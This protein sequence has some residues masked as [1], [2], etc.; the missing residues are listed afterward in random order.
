MAKASTSRNILEKAGQ[1]VAPLATSKQP[2]ASNTSRL[3]S[4]PSVQQPVPPAQMNNMLMM[5]M[6]RR[7]QKPK[8]NIGQN[9]VGNQQPEA[10][11][12]QNEV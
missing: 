10:N 1:P 8:A 6:A 5:A 7:N 2:S 4:T 9:V 11:I 12:R 3:S